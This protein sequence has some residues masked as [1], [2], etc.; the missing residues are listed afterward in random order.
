MDAKE[1]GV[2][3]TETI[4][5]EAREWCRRLTEELEPLDRDC[6]QTEWDAECSGDDAA[7]A[8]LADLRRKIMRRLS[9]ADDFAE[10]TRLLNSGSLANPLLRREVLR[11]RN[12]LAARQCPPELNDRLAAEET[13]LSQQFNSF[14]ATHHGKSVG[15]NELQKVLRETRDSA[16]AEA[17]WRASKAIASHVGDSDS[18]TVAQRL[19]DVVKLRNEAAQA[20]GYPTAY[21]AALELSELSEEWLFDTLAK[22]EAETAAPFARYKERLDHWLAAHFAIQKE[23]L[24]PWHYGDLFFQT[25]R[26]I[27]ADED[28]QPYLDKTHLDIVETTIKTMDDLGFDIRP[29][30]ARSDLFPGNPNGSRKCQ[31]AFCNS[32]NVPDDVRVLCNIVRN[33]RWLSTNLHEF[34]HAVYGASIDAGLPYILRDDPHLLCNEAIALLME[35]H[36][37]DEDWLGKYL[38]MNS[39]ESA[40]FAKAGRHKLAIKHLV[41]TRWVLVMC[42]FERDLYLDPDRADLSELWWSYVQRFQMLTPPDSTTWN[43]EWASKIHF[44]GYP[45]YY[46][47]YLLGEIFGASLQRAMEK[48]CGPFAGNRRAGDFLR[49]RMFR[50]GASLHWRDLTEAVTGA[51]FATRDFS[52]TLLYAADR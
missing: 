31:H 7:F 25:S 45:A 16:E 36:L 27:H 15:D 49:E 26:P 38:G 22:L 40:H 21:R 39:D 35:R 50:Q 3:S 4:E 20:I 2:E 11:W 51:P 19:I 28:L 47:N 33:E 6:R 23:D 30:V 37:L 9:D 44:T 41:F 12:R 1:R 48:E 52:E 8:R 14:R 18:R 5:R 10:G 43:H 24:R 32:I 17:A 42:Y 46:Q 13:A 34:G 29:I